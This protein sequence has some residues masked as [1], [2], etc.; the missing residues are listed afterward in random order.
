MKTLRT[1]CLTFIALL[2][3][4]TAF[5]QVPPPKHESRIHHLF[6]SHRDTSNLEQRYKDLS[7]ALVVIRAGDKI[8]TGFYIGSDG[9][10][11]TASHV[12]GDRLFI[13]EGQQMRIT[14]P[15]PQEIIIKNS[16]GEFTI[17]ASSLENNADHWAVDLALLKTRRPTSCWLGIGDDKAARRGQRVIAMGFPGLAF[18]SLSLY[19]GIISARLKSDLLI[20]TTVQGKPLKGENDLLRVQ[21]PISPGISGAPI[22]DDENRV[23]AVVTTA[24]AW[25]RDLDVLAR[26]SRTGAMPPSAPNTISLP[27]ALAQFARIFHDYFSPGYGDAV[28]LSYLTKKVQQEN[29]QSSSPAH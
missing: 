5:A 25:S 19:S 16:M 24:G 14:I 22:I 18:G 13:P 4:W 8:G 29:Q 23:I 9:D 7:C 27:S 3:S 2:L 15:L 11:V 20:G 6:A 26:L 28:P 12:L 21:M 17:P 1:I 10:V